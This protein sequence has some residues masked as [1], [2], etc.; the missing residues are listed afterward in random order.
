MTVLSQFALP[1]EIRAVLGV[2]QEEITDLTLA[3]PLYL[4]Q[5]QFELSDI[6][7]NLEST[8]LSIAALSSRTVAEQKLY[9]VMQAF[10]PYSVG[11]IL[12][13]SVTLFAPKRITD[14]KA[15]MERIIDPFSDVK[16]GVIAAYNSLYDRLRSA[17]EALGN[18]MAT[19]SRTWTYAVSAGLATDPVTNA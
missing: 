10:A 3:M 18:T 17:Y 4:R 13:G 11:R 8:Y 7:E 15:E 16:E 19:Q 5:L 12:L 2:S 6:D 1:D 9:D 14:G